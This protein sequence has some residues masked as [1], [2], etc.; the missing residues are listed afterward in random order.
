[1]VTDRIT[2]FTD[3][4][5][6]LESGEELQ[7]DI[8]VTA[9]GLQLLALGGMTLTVDG[10]EVD[11][12]QTVTYKG[13]MLAGVPNCAMTIGYT[14]ASW[15]LKADLVAQYVCRLIRHM[16]RRGY[17]TCTPIAPEAG[18]LHPLIDFTSG[19]VRRSV[20]ALPKQGSAPPWRLYQSYPRDL[21]L[22][23]FGR[24][25][26]KGMRF[27][28]RAQLRTLDPDAAE[29]QRQRP[30]EDLR[31]PGKRAL[32]CTF[33]RKAAITQKRTAIGGDLVGAPGL[34]REVVVPQRDRRARV[35]SPGAAAATRRASCRPRSDRPT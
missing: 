28:R 20:D 21:I 18:E 4:G 14:N 2:T 10:T 3:E 27:A 7:A 23:R 32:Q 17:A 19:Y 12:S 6:V 16:D 15:T 31:F 24:L 9:T 22:M 5:I 1:M 11:L 29:L 25:E 33:P 30:I 35:R 13:M 8:V 34:L 26:D